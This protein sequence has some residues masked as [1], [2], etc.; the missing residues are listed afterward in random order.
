MFDRVNKMKLKKKKAFDVMR[1][2]NFLA[3]LRLNFQYSIY[4]DY[5]LMLRRK[6]FTNSVSGRPGI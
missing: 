6:Y 1:K 3:C 5:S 4:I 2:Q